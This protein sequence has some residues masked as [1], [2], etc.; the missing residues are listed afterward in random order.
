MDDKKKVEID[1]LFWEVG[2]ERWERNIDNDE[3]VFKIFDEEVFYWEMKR[4]YLI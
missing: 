1:S 2:K 4:I 3:L